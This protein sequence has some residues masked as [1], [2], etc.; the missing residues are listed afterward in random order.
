MNPIPSRRRRPGAMADIPPDLPQARRALIEEMRDGRSKAGLALQN[1]AHEMYS[2]KASVSR[3]LNGQALPT[4]DQAA[5]W[6][7]VCGTDVEMLLALWDA[8]AGQ[9][10]PPSAPKADAHSDKANAESSESRVTDVGATAAERQPKRIWLRRL[11]S[12]HVPWIA[13]PIAL[14]VLV[15][16]V[17]DIAT[18]H[19]VPSAMPPTTPCSMTQS[20]PAADQ[21][22]PAH[23]DDLT[24][25]LVNINGGTLPITGPFELAGQVLGPASQRQRVVLVNYGDPRTCDALGNP[26]AAGIFLLNQVN[27][28]SFDGSWSYVDHLGYPEAVT[29]A[30]TFE[31]ITASAASIQLMKDDRSMWAA[32]GNNPDDYPGIRAMPADANVLARFKVPAGIYKRKTIPCKR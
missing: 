14:V 13:G 19:K 6:A 8:N 3:W 20:G 16:Y 2:S 12:S 10:P 27:L 21:P 30:R 24:F 4:R 18:S 11:V 23:A 22:S 9:A 32:G 25:C 1:L 15:G 31:Y 17:A 7:Q 26:P 28:G 29:I 5:R